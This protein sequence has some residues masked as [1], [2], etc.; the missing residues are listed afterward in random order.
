MLRKKAKLNM[1]VSYHDSGMLGPTTDRKPIATQSQV[2]DENQ[3]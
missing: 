3:F 1:E 2:T